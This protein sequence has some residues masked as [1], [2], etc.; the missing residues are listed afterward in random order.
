MF[1]LSF[2]NIMSWSTWEG[3]VGWYNLFQRDT[4][5]ITC[6]NWLPRREQENWL[7]C[8]WKEATLQGR[9]WDDY[10]QM[11]QHGCLGLVNGAWVQM[12]GRPVT[13]LR[14]WV[15]LWA[16]DL[17]VKWKWCGDSLRCRRRVACINLCWL[18]MLL[19]HGPQWEVW[20]ETYFPH[21]FKHASQKGLGY[22]VTLKGEVR[23]ISNGKY[24]PKFW[25]I[26][27][28]PNFM[29][30][31]VSVFSWQQLV[32]LILWGLL[33]SKLSGLVIN[34]LIGWELNIIHIYISC[35]F[36]WISFI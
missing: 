33:V 31:Y 8:S 6:T 17:C 4:F 20:L 29:H 5:E 16:S 21:S 35:N 15:K 18:L 1:F 25:E 30:F 14:L 12:W 28:A 9:K 26:H 3:F 2:L 10:V 27:H 24:S 22:T 13:L 11:V 7:S 36:L 19:I 34:F 23:W 32:L